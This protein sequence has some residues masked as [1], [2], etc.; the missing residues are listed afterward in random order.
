MLVVDIKNPRTSVENLF[1]DDVAVILASKKLSQFIPGH[2]ITEARS[3]RRRPTLSRIRAPRVDDRLFLSAVDPYRCAVA[4]I[5]AFVTPRC[6]TPL[7]Q[8]NPV[9]KFWLFFPPPDL[10]LLASNCSIGELKHR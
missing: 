10:N 3:Q 1:I 2:S 7:V 6:D 8:D 9:P 4:V 5:S